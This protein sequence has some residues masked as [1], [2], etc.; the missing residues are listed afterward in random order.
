M[1]YRFLYFLASGVNN[2]SSKAVVIAIINNNGTIELQAYA[3]P[4]ST[5]HNP[6]LG[7]CLNNTFKITN[8]IVV[9]KHI[10]NAIFWPIVPSINP[11]MVNINIGNMVINND[12]K[13]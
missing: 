5:I 3:S 8:I 12:K 6:H 11:N 2:S 9:S 13:L 10:P 4:V 1:V 7:I